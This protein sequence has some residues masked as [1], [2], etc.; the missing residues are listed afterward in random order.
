MR[1]K[2]SA[3]IKSLPLGARGERKSQTAWLFPPSADAAVPQRM[4]F[5]PK[6]EKTDEGGRSSPSTTSSGAPRHLPLSRGR[7]TGAAHCFYGKRQPKSLPLRQSR[8]AGKV[9]VRPTGELTDE[10]KEGDLTK[11]VSITA[12]LISHLRPAGLLTA[13]PP[14]GEANA[15]RSI[16][17]ERTTKSLLPSGGARGVK[18]KPN[19]LAFSAERR[20]GCAASDGFSTN[21]RT[22]G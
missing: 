18:K 1:G 4:D 21:G 5:R 17:R 14:K 13:S 16:I 3:L 10:G 6:G 8:N 7:N 11:Q 12:P 2:E 9:A 19:G 22:D 15:P 20:C